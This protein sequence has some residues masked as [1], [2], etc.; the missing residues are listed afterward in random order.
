M[1][2]DDDD[3]FHVL[4]DGVIFCKLI[5]CAVPDTIDMRVV[6][7]GA[8][9]NIYKVRENLN[10]ACA[11]CT[12]IG[13]KMIGIDANAFLDKKEHLILA[14]LWQ[15]MKLISTKSVSLKDC[16]EIYRLLNEGE[17]LSELNKLQPDQLLIRWMNFHLKN[18]GSEPIKNLGK[19][20]A[21]GKAVIKVLNQLDERCTTEALNEEDDV[22]RC[23][24]AVDNSKII[25]VADVIC[26]E[27]LNKGNSK[28]N[29]IFVGE[30]FNA[31]HGLQE[32]S[33][34]EY[35]AA[36]LIDDDIEGTI[37][38]R[39]FR[40][41]IN[42][43]GIEDV[44]VNDLFAEA[45]D[46]L[47]LLK[48]IHKINPN[49]VEWN[50]VEKNPNSVF[51]RGINCQVAIDACKKMNIVL[52]GIGAE[53]IRDSNKKLILAIVWQLVRIHY[54]QIIGSKTENDLVKWA[55]DLVKDPQIGNLKD[56]SMKDGRFLI[57]L[58]AGIEPR[59]VNWELV[60]PGETEEDAMM[61]AK[62]AISVA[63]MLGAVIFM[64]WDDIP[65]VNY[66]MILIFVSS[67]YEIQ[68]EM[69]QKKKEEA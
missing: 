56:K 46:G 31:K 20:L 23:N 43:L 6:N 63:R 17:E 49:V 7:K 61:N 50:R 41:W 52:A 47:L 3:V 28:V 66:K 55:N 58:C 29:V 21:D 48:V 26:G 18:A 1:N 9:I 13:I 64:V 51:K 42:S 53:D 39:Q 35:E 40:L 15:L 24:K 11:A 27:D 5:N 12:G 60:T 34:E 25:E 19:D 69:A 14:V 33:K 44:Y 32:L 30:M 8:N 10:L 67:L 65:K 62:Y 37:E 38:E 4:E 54:L 22:T 16:P 59:A 45:S 68:E 36:T 57:K 2:P